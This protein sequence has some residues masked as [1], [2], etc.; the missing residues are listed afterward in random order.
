MQCNY[1]CSH[2][3][4]R[5]WKP[6]R[7]YLWHNRAYR[8]SSSGRLD[9]AAHKEGGPAVQRRLVDRQRGGESDRRRRRGRWL[10]FDSKTTASAASEI[11]SC[12]GEAEA[13]PGPAAATTVT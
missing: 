5:T 4:A 3:Q 9:T 10:G 11:G 12:G 13:V 2:T 6:A 8:S 1:Y 7:T